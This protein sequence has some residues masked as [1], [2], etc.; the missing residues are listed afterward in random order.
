MT[1]SS[2]QLKSTVSARKAI[3]ILIAAAWLAAAAIAQGDATPTT[4]SE[5]D[6]LPPTDLRRICASGK[7][8]VA[9]YRGERPPFFTEIA[10]RD[11]WATTEQAWQ[12]FDVDLARDI[13]KRLGVT[14]EARLA[15]SFDEVVE[16]VATRQADLGLSKLSITL[17]R[18]QRVRF[19]SPY[20]TVYQTL[21]INRL[22]APKQEDPFVFLNRANARVGAL[23][24]S[25]YIEYAANVFP[26]ADLAPYTDF[27][28]MMVDVAENRLDAAL[29]DS[30]RANTWRQSNPQLLINVRAFIARDRKDSLAMAVNWEDTHL[31]AWLDLYLDSIRDDGSAAALFG[32]WFRADGS[33]GGE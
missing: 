1:A 9:R 4:A 14:Y 28:Q 26:A 2:G 29:V 21:L 20:M 27:E 30:A 3:P 12:G 15:D 7:L 23:E 18:S 25:S 10:S 16:L 13:A 19:T 17:A 31:L 8:V 5:C 32:E 22:A 24:G 33:E 11:R 6:H